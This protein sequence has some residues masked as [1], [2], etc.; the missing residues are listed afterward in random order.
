[1]VVRP[2]GSAPYTSLELDFSQPALPAFPPVLAVNLAHP[3]LLLLTRFVEDILYAADTLQVGPVLRPICPM[4]L[5]LLRS[6]RAC[7]FLSYAS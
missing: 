3:R 5:P 2:N 6:W 7:S 1:M 4:M